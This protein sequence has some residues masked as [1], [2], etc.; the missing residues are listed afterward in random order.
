MTALTKVLTALRWAISLELRSYGGAFR[1]LTRRFDVPPG[2]R[3]HGYVGAVAALLW[4]FTIVSAVELVVVHLIVPWERVRR[5]LDVLGIWGVLWCLGFTGCH[6]AFPHLLTDSSLRVRFAARPDVVTIPLAS[7]ASVGARERSHQGSRSVRVDAEAGS[8]V[9][10]VGGRTN[11]DLRLSRPLA[12]SVRGRTH[13][14][15][16]VRIFSDDARG[17]L[18]ALRQHLG[19]GAD[20]PG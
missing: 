17:A 15:Q 1:L 5:P 9:V 6:Y 19:S 7:L 16:E 3:P 2:S 13:L 4:G 20:Q 18:T 14:V 8:L 10:A 12:V 11:L